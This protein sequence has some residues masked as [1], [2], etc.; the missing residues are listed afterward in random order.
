L[1]NQNSA[2]VF[3]GD[4]CKFLKA[5]IK[6]NNAGRILTGSGDPTDSP[7]YAEAG[8]IYMRSGVGTAGIY[9]KNDNGLTANWTRVDPFD[10][11]MLTHNDTTNAYVAGGFLQ[12]PDGKM[13]AT[14]DGLGSSYTNYYV[15]LTL[16]L[17]TLIP[18]PVNNTTYSVYLNLATLNLAPSVITETGISVYPAQA[19]NFIAVTT[20]PENALQSYIYIGSVRRGVGA[21]ATNHS[22][23]PLRCPAWKLTTAS[24]VVFT[25]TKMPIGSVGTADQIGAGH[26]LAVD[27]FPSGV[28]ATTDCSWWNLQSTS[29]DGNTLNTRN[30]TQV[31]GGGFTGTGLF[32]EAASAWIGGSA[33]LA[34]TDMFFSP[35]G[36]AFVPFTAAGWFEYNFGSSSGSCF[37]S[38]ASSTSDRSWE[39]RVPAGTPLTLELAYYAS[40][41]SGS[42]ASYTRSIPIVL[43]NF[44]TLGVGRHHLAV[45]ATAGLIQVLINGVVAGSSALTMRGTMSTGQF[46]IGQDITATATAYGGSVREAAFVRAALEIG[47]IRKL[48]AYKLVHNRE[49]LSVDQDWIASL[50]SALGPEEVPTDWIVDKS[51]S[52]SVYWWLNGQL[53]ATKFG[54]KLMNMSAAPSTIVQSKS[55]DSGWLSAAPTFPFPHGQP[56]VPSVV[57]MYEES[58][59]VFT[60]LAPDSYLKWD[61]TNFTGDSAAIALL[62]LSATKRIR[63]LAATGYPRPLI[64]SGM[65]SLTDPGL[66]S[67][68]AQAFAGQKTFSEGILV[69]DGSAA[70]PSVAFASD[71]DTG[72]YKAGD[73]SVGFSF[74][75]VGVLGYL[76]GAWTFGPPTGGDL[77]HLFRSGGATTLTI[78]GGTSS[79]ASLNLDYNGGASTYQ[80]INNAG[81]LNFRDAGLASVNGVVTAP[82]QWTLGPATGLTTS[83]I[84]RNSNVGQAVLTIDG[85][86]LATAY[87]L[88]VQA[89]DGTGAT[90]S[91][92]QLNRGNAGA[93][94][95][96]VR[97]DGRTLFGL[98]GGMGSMSAAGTWKLGSAAQTTTQ[99]N[100]IL[101]VRGV[102]V[103]S[104]EWGHSNPAGYGSVLSHKTGNGQPI[105]GLC[106]EIGTDT[107][108]Y[109]TRGIKGTVLESDLAGGLIFGSVQTVT[110]DNLT[111][112]VMG[113]FV[114]TGAW[115][116]GPPAGGVAHTFRGTVTATAVYNAVY[117]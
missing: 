105:I 100:A 63:I 50:Q 75:G 16:T 24:P 22:S 85:G 10:D 99:S 19:A 8:S 1:G 17:A 20:T 69:P 93:T 25:Q 78:R 101:S 58:P 66:V 67:I 34:R 49:V 52:N 21:W 76:A 108:N 27:S 96:E 116:F 48:G 3:N 87:G 117:N 82:G 31:G 114:T 45:R 72:M 23:A 51:S 92:L 33:Y 70:A 2:V 89:G 59:G 13:V 28:V 110:G 40:G 77:S 9:F 4:F 41:D 12:L 7:L 53:S 42:G 37:M 97:G 79:N 74:G 83:H 18:T 71:T 35:G 15:G 55:F 113:F 88:I 64:V 107:N 26:T 104:F 65:A 106:C 14:W 29:S 57:V 36:L 86:L 68:T 54:A 115:T 94:Y 39:L 30:L 43:S 90:C 46:R 98:A 47:S 80:I 6:L 81:S 62:G 91:L 111:A 60:Q 84:I 109:R 73:N 103:N 95:F 11:L 112:A 102:S 38:V 32:G 56:D 44:V 5:Q 61:G